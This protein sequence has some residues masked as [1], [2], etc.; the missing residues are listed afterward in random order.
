MSSW[1]PP[2]IKIIYIM[3]LERG[4]TARQIIADYANVMIVHIMFEDC[5]KDIHMQR[6]PATKQ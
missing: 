1:F 4:Y 3:I 5:V 6:Q 2:H